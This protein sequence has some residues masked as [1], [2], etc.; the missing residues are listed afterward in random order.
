MK[1][2][3]SLIVIA[4]RFTSMASMIGLEKMTWFQK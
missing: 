1:V 4:K 3:V 2:G